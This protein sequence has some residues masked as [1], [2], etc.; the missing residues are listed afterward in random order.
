MIAGTLFCLFL[1]VL[2]VCF[3]T[4][5]LTFFPSFVYTSVCVLR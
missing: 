1:S 4:L 3:M 2:R 5:T